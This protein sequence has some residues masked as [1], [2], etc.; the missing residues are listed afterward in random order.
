MES[1]FIALRKQLEYDLEKTKTKLEVLD[2]LWSQYASGKA[3][4]TT[5]NEVVCTQN[6]Q[7]VQ[8]L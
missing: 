7:E 1:A 2:E 8:E 6:P 4:Q 5:D 3:T